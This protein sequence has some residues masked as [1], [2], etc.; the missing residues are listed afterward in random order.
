MKP[1]T[2]AEPKTIKLSDAGTELVIKPAPDKYVVAIDPQI[3]KNGFLIVRAGTLYGAISEKFTHANMACK[4]PAVHHFRTYYKSGHKR[5]RVKIGSDLYFII[6]TDKVEL[7]YK[8]GYSYIYGLINGVKVGFNVTG[9]YGG[10]CSTDFLDLV[11][12]IACGHKLRDLKKLAEVALPPAKIDM[13]LLE[14]LAKPLGT[15]KQRDYDRILAEHQGLENLLTLA[16]SKIVS[17]I[18]LSGDLTYGSGEVADLVEILHCKKLV[19]GAKKPDGW[20]PATYKDTERIKGFIVNLNGSHFRVKKTHI[21]WAGTLKLNEATTQI[22][23][24][25]MVD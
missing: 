10:D 16:D 18:K 17:Q 5:W 2:E 13:A 14:K 15:D 7:A 6:P 19:Y 8:E 22:L 3:H 25:Q 9:M 21:N 4:K 24:G 11:A 20:T 1:E 23:N 12:D